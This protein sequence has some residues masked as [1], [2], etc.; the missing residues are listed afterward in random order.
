MKYQYTVYCSKEKLRDIRRFVKST[1]DK[2][3]FSEIDVSTL[4]LAIDEVCANLIIHGHSCAANESFDIEIDVKG[5][6]L[7]FDIIDTSDMFDINKYEEPSIEDII[8][9]QRKGGLGLMLVKR[10]MDDIE[11]I[12]STKKSICRLVKNVDN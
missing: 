4:V 7:V 10:I 5:S 11:V 8:K 6:H 2:Q 12:T 3:G 1:L 9:K